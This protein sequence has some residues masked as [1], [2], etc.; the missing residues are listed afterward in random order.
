MLTVFHSWKHHRLKSEKF[1]AQLTMN[2]GERE[3]DEEKQNVH[4]WERKCQQI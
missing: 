1:L 2:E 3:G 4:Q